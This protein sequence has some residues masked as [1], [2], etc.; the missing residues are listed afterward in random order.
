MLKKDKKKKEYQM[1]QSKELYHLFK[2]LNIVEN[3]FC[4][5]IIANHIIHIKY[6]RSFL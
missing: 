6:R 2:V 1:E 5:R 4:S 3:Y